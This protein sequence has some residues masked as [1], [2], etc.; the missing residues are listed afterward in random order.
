MGKDELE[1]DCAAPRALDSPLADLGFESS[2]M[3][4]RIRGLVDGVGPAGSEAGVWI[5]F[6]NQLA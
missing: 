1:T 2:G 6:E 3:V 5:F 4:P